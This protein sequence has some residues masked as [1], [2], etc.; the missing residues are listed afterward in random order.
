[1]DQIGV[2]ARQVNFLDKRLVD[3][4]SAHREMLD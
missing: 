4:D 2:L 3:F 1:M